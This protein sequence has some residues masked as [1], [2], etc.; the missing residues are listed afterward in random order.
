MA[1]KWYLGGFL[2]QLMDRYYRIPVVRRLV[3]A[4]WTEHLEMIRGPWSPIRE[5]LFEIP[6]ERS[7]H[8]E[9]RW[10]E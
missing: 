7:P 9:D 3:Q 6:W 8:P 1:W 2:D 4:T 5:E 10:R